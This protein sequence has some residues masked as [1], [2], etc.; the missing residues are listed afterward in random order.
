MAGTVPPGRLIHVTELVDDVRPITLRALAALLW[1][2]AVV[3][4]GL[5]GWLLYTDV[6]REPGSR[7]LATFVTAYTGVYAAVLGLVGWA[8]FRRKSWSRGPAMMLEL[9]L[10]PIGYYMI[11]GGQPL[12][13]VPTI[14]LGALGVV[15]TVAPATRRALGLEPPTAPSVGLGQG[16]S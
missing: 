7:Q 10:F 11:V 14:L 12:L 1:G 8:V 3:L 6:T 13:G 16:E 2:K 5:T 15:L 9:F 4:A